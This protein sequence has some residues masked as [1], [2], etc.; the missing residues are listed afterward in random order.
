MK[1]FYFV[2]DTNAPDGLFQPKE[3]NPMTPEVTMKNLPL[4]DLDKYAY[5]DSDDAE[6]FVNRHPERPG[7][8]VRQVQMKVTL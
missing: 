7:F 2:Q 5:R 3:G 6:A 8:Q 4:S 1:T